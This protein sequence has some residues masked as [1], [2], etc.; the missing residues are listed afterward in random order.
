MSTYIAL[1][2]W[3]PEGVRAV[4]NAAD[5]LDAVKK[6]L[7]DMDCHHHS[8]HMTKGEYDP[9]LIYDAP[10]DAFAARLTLPRTNRCA[11]SGRNTDCEVR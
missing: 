8:I 9:V 11:G 2:N 6:L 4:G 10:D 7:A 1:A 5:R 3:T